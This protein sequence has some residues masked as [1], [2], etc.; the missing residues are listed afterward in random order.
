MIGHQAVRQQPHA[1]A[2][3]RLTKQPEKG[4]VILVIMKDGHLPVAT[5]QNVVANIPSGG[6]SSARHAPILAG[7][8]NRVNNVE[9]P[10]F[11]PG[12]VG[13]SFPW[14]DAHGY[15]MSPLRG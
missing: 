14:A 3:I 1:N 2:M 13:N 8:G 9:C 11:L 6:A 5:I 15:I 7:N 10:L 4:E 12:A